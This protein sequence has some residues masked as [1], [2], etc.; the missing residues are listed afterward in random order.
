MSGKKKSVAAALTSSTATTTL[1]ALAVASV[2]LVTVG[3]VVAKKRQ[4][5]IALSRVQP[6][7][8][9]KDEV[10]SNAEPMD[11]D[12]PARPPTYDGSKGWAK[13]LDA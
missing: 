1:V 9:E 7:N 5:S 3:V 10:N 12:A 8:A 2:A 4:A 11:V 6:F 13:E